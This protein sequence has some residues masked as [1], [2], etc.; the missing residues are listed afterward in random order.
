MEK[1]LAAVRT[2]PSKTEIREFPDAGHC[3]RRRAHENGS[4][5]HLRHRCQDLQDAAHR[6]A[7]DHGAREH[8][9]YR[10]GRAANSPAARASRKATW[11]SSST[12]SCAA[13]AN[14]AIRA[15]TA[16]ARTPTGATIPTHPLRLHLGREG[17]ASVG[18]LRAI[19]LSAVERGRASR[20]AG[21]DA[22]TRRH[23]DADGQRHPMGAV[24]GRRRLQF[25]GADP[26]SRPA[27]PVADRHLQAG[28]R[29]AASSSPAPPRT[30]RGWKSPRS[31]APTTSS[32]C[33]R[34][35]RSRASW[36]SPAARAWM[37]SLD[38]TAGAG[39][40]PILLGV[41]ALKRKAGTIVVQGEMADFP[42]FP[43]GRVT[44]KY[45]T[46][47]SARGHS[48]KACELALAQLASKRFPLGA[49]HHPQVRP[50]R[51]RPG[52]QARSAARACRTS[53]TPR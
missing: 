5:R 45:I 10:Q 53:S 1:V 6:R 33:R 43:L 3:G 8:R 24:R 27:G 23:G 21:R 52:D 37:S 30:P 36:R 7:R 14:G 28:R 50:E 34:K 20:A 31:S 47:K 32:T 9:L 2:G 12:T 19:S 44:V 26:G 48:Y 15:N 11:C 16:I 22:G 41:E 49:D 35:T 29:L 25:D 18:R 38:C 51:C 39:T 17:A 42:N 4:R 13:N 46:I 40:L